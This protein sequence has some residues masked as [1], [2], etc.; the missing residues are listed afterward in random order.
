M[1]CLEKIHLTFVYILVTRNF[2]GGWCGAVIIKY[3]HSWV[4]TPS[5]A[6][7]VFLSKSVYPHGFNN[8]LFQE[9][10]QDD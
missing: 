6:P 3:S 1:T 8:S 7:V 5:K 9:R 10:I 2:R 4:R